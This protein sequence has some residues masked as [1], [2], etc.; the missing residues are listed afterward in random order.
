MLLLYMGMR[1][2]KTIVGLKYRLFA[3][4]GYLPDIEECAT[5]HLIRVVLIPI[6]VGGSFYANRM[7][8]GMA[9]NYK[10]FWSD[11]SAS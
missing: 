9:N 4:T 6:H 2:G 1:N 10:P 7:R 8:V 5:C 11:F 3:K